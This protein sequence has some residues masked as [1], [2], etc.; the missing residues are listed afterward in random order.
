MRR[1][2]VL[3]IALS[4]LTS[5][6][7]TLEIS[8]ETAPS[9]IADVSVGSPLEATA[10]SILSMTSS[11]EEIRTAMLQSADK[12]N[13]IW[14]DGLVTWYPTDG[15][16]S[17]PQVYREQVWIETSTPRFRTLLGPGEGEAEQFTACDGTSILRIDLKSGRSESNS[18]PTF[19][20]EA[21]TDSSPH[22]LWGQI[23]TPI[24][25]IALSSNYA[26]DQGVYKP[27][28]M[29]IIAERETLIVELTRLSAELPQ[30]RM[31]LDTQTAVILKL[32]EFGKGGGEEVLGERV[33]NRVV[34]DEPFAD[35]LFRAPSSL[36]QFS[37]VVGTPLLSSEPALTASS[38]PDPL[39]EVYF[40]AGD[41]N[42]GNE[43]TLLVR[44]P[45]SCAAGLSPCPEAEVIAPPFGLNFSLTSLVWAPDGDIAAFSYPISDD[46]NKSALFLF[47]PQTQAW[48]SIAEFNFID[49]PFWSPDGNWLAFRVQDGNGSDEI[50]AIRRDGSQLTNLTESEKLPSEDS[51]YTLSG[52]I[53]NYVILH[54]RTSGILY[55]LRPEDGAVTPLFGTPVAKS[56][57]VVPS[58]DGYFLAYTD[59]SDQKITL[60]L[61]TPDGST[62]RDLAAFQNTS[63]Y[64]IVWSPDGT[65]VAFATTTNG[66][67]PTS[68]QDVYVIGSNGR[69][70]QQVYHS[71]SASIA[72][73]IFSPDGNYVLLQDDVAAGRHIFVINL[74]TLQQHMLKVPNIPLDWWWL[75]PSWR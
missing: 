42:Y 45:G 69:S 44:V 75:A 41:H 36:P 7:G 53:N 48:Q 22:M 49:P 16:D 25:E 11:S 14:I 9:E 5:A 59:A 71:A 17:P 62:A 23:G 40:F 38:D 28:G 39:R 47:D 46:G 65:R 21:P 74:S 64:P 63:I 31:W 24:S 55:L 8:L 26:T 13:T 1:F 67:D 54:S 73:I 43:K 52:W 6:C 12:W 72:D 10:E 32:Q 61:L 3:F 70:L 66:R 60:K 30:W 18:L 15:S 34:Y 57:L 68:G 56:D 19:A 27:T 2:T 58:P 4:L 51:P 29:E 35:A 33:V 37:D 20:K 50:Y